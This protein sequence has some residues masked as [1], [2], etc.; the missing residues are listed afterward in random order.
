MYTQ[1]PF[2]A[3]TAVPAGPSLLSAAFAGGL[4]GSG[5]GAPF[6]GAPSPSSTRWN[7]APLSASISDPAAFGGDARPPPALV[8]RRLPQ[9]ISSEAL[10]SMLIFAGDLLD[11]EIIRSPYKE[12]RGFATAVARFQSHAGALEAQQKLHGKPNATKEANMIVEIHSGSMAGSFARS[13]SDGLIPRTQ[14]SSTSSAGSSGGPP[15]TSRS[16]FNSTFQSTE[17]NSPPL[18]T[19]SSS[20]G[21]AT[22]SGS[23]E[24]P[25]P[26][27]SSRMSTL[28]SPQSPVANGVDGRRVSGKSMINDDDAG[29]DE[30]GELLKDPIGYARSGQQ[31]HAGPPPNKSAHAH[32]T[33]RQ[34]V[35]EH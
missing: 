11:T 30:T 31:P 6:Y 23:A 14:A 10:G 35:A 15:I 18:P 22:S 16:R 33:L 25:M 1:S 13:T 8:I 28:F 32:W 20:G 19:P 27:S 26:E 9:N 4:S 7:L 17:K 34:L 12:D 24:L 3:S 21:S 2:A 29:D 5:S